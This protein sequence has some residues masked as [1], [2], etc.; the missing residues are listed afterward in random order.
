MFIYQIGDA[1]K[2]SKRQCW[3][4]NEI[5]VLCIAYAYTAV[6]QGI[7]DEQT[8]RVLTNRLLYPIFVLE[9]TDRLAEEKPAHLQTVL[10]NEM[11]V[12]DHVVPCVENVAVEVSK[13]DIRLYSSF[14]HR[15]ST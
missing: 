4:Q 12:K 9:Q 2:I 3:Y 7:T 1:I 14:R 11:E 13:A 6:I 8:H 5:H 10:S 15:I